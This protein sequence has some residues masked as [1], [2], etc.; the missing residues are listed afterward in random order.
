[1]DENR[2]HNQRTWHHKFG[3]IH[4]QS[5]VA[6][7]RNQNARLTLWSKM[8]IKIFSSSKKRCNFHSR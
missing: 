5:T 7:S 1:M 2:H 8:G 4:K 6:L 3:A